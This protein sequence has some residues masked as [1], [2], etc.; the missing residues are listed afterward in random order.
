LIDILVHLAK[1]KK[2]EFVYKGQ[3]RYSIVDFVNKAISTAERSSCEVVTGED[4][5]QGILDNT[6][7]AFK[8]IFNENLAAST[9][10]NTQ[11]E[12]LLAGLEKLQAHYQTLE[13]DYYGKYPFGKCFQEVVA[14]LSDWTK[15]RAPK[16][17]FQAL[18]DGQLDS[19][20]RFDT[21]KG[22]ADFANR[23]LREYDA[24]KEFYSDNKENFKELPKVDQD[25]AAELDKFLRMDDPRKDFRHVLKAKQELE[26]ALDEHISDLR[27][28]VE[29]RYLDLYTELNE[30][31]HKRGVDYNS[32]AAKE[33]TL[34]G[35]RSLNSISTLKLRELNAQNF[36]RSEL[37]TIINASPLL[38]GEPEIDRRPETYHV[39]AKATTISTEAE[40]DTYLQLVRKEML[41]LLKNN[42]TIILK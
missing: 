21:A 37:E 31:A 8:Y 9:D 3:Q 14:Q 33:Y 35:I 10:G 27:Q 2:R 28:K 15:I 22:I 16:K 18:I 30:E 34:K 25:K 23:G 12:L 36:K 20:E 29:Q 1:K 19:K 5:D 17:L 4:I 40:L 38:A 41:A 39:S 6:L 11:Y 42:K 7:K 26:Q 13:R 32:D 24:L